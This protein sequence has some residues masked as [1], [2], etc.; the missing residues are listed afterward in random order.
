[1]KSFSS[2]E[3]DHLTLINVYRASTE[4][5]EKRNLTFGKEK[6]DKILR[7]WCK[8]NFINNRSLRHARDIHRLVMLIPCFNEYVYIDRLCSWLDARQSD[9]YLPLLDMC[10]LAAKFEVIL[11]KWVFILP[12]VEMTCYSSADVLLLRSS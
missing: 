2:P 1:M 4:F 6:A 12:L 9:P 8:E 10:F 3:G 7:K 5:M 11:N